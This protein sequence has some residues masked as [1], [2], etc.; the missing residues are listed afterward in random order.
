MY[1]G[2]SVPDDAQRRILALEHENAKLRKINAVLIDRAERGTGLQGDPF[3][4]FQT[5]VELEAQVR[6]RTR[7]LRDALAELEQSNQALRA[8]KEEAETAQLRL[9][10]AIESVSEGFVLCDAQDRLVMC[11]SKYREFWPALADIIRPGVK[12]AALVQAAEARGL[13]DSSDGRTES[14]MQLRLQHHRQPRDLL[15][16][17]LADGRWLQISERSIADG[18]S[19]AIYTDITEIKLSEQR[20]RERELAEKNALLQA[21]FDTISQGVAVVDQDQRLVASNQRFLELLNIAPDQATVGAALRELVRLPVDGGSQGGLPAAFCVEHITGTG[22][23]LEIRSSPM[24]NGGMV[25][26]YTDITERKASEWALRESEQRIRLITDAIP[27]LIAYVDASG[28]YRFTNKPYEDWFGRPRSEINGRHM[29]A[30]LG[31]DL[32]EARSEHVDTVLAGHRVTFEVRLPM[33]RGSIEHALATYVPHFGPNGD[34]LGFFALIQDITERKKAAEQLREAKE[35]LERRVAER[36]TELTGLN[37]RLQ[38]EVE[39]R[40]QAQ[41]ALQVAKAEAE[42]ANMSKT[43]F[44]AA[45]SHDLLQPLNAARM[46]ATALGE[47]R[48]APRNR[49]FARNVITAL[50][51]VDELLCALLDI[52]KLDAGAH[53]TDIVDFRIDRLLTALCDEFD[54]QARARNLALRRVRCRAVVRTDAVLVGRILRNF[55]SNAMRYSP[56]GRI[57][58]GCRRRADGLEVQVWDTGIGIPGDKLGEVFDEFRRLAVDSHDRDRGMGLGLAIVDRIARRLGHPITVR[59]AVGQG[60]MFGVV[61]PY[62]SA[63][64][65]RPQAA[66]FALSGRLDRVAGAFVVVVEND[67]AARDGLSA[68]LRSWHCTVLAADSPAAAVQALDAQ[69][70]EPDVLI[71]DYHLND[72]EIGVSA[73]AAIAGRCQRPIPAIITTAD[74]TDA[75]RDA[76]REAGLHLL[77]KPLK[78]A[79]LRSLLAH[80]VA[81]GAVPDAGATPP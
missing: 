63:T 3:S 77:N 62:G 52:S 61:L 67:E 32:F 7:R 12:F 23:F 15:V 46:F 10:T 66:T 18:G 80:L 58:L 13:F 14:P 34:V 26:T 41:A 59:S 8:A 51:A 49:G 78:P 2:I 31:E 56:A 72:G 64:R 21:T 5:A 39:E 71:A 42:Q 36:T 20:Q 47:S 45:A 54:P 48:L 40:R 28:R 43:K 11:N 55:L 69:P 16:I 79:R 57:L 44:I 22:T 75:V 38:E 6:D 29:R 1:G 4:L 19:V 60:S 17:R 30:V 33:I 81:P 76:V 25:S 27:A 53:A 50:N 74:R 65:I 35:G 37:N 70:R 73:L 24:P 68:L 9:A